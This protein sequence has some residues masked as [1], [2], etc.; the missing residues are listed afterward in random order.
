MKYFKDLFRIFV[1]IFPFLCTE[2]F[3]FSLSAQEESEIPAEIQSTARQVL[4]VMKEAASKSSPWDSFQAKLQKIREVGSSMFFPLLWNQRQAYVCWEA[5]HGLYML[6]WEKDGFKSGTAGE[7]F[8]NPGLYT[9]VAFDRLLLSDPKLLEEAV[10]SLEFLKLWIPDLPSSVK[11][12]PSLQT[13]QSYLFQISKP[14]KNYTLAAVIGEDR[15]FPDLT[16]ADHELC[17]LHFPLIHFTTSENRKLSFCK[18]EDPVLLKRIPLLL[19]RYWADTE[20]K[21]FFNKTFAMKERGLRDA[22]FND[23]LFYDELK[24]ILQEVSQKYDFSNIPEQYLKPLRRNIENFLVCNGIYSLEALKTEDAF[25]KLK[26]AER[27]CSAKTTA[28]FRDWREMKYLSRWWSER[29]EKAEEE[30]RPVKIK[31]YG[32]ST[33]QEI[34]SYAMD[35][36]S[37]GINNFKILASDIDPKMITEASE[38]TYS[39]DK[40]S[41]LTFKQYDQVMSEFFEKKE[42]G[43]YRLKYKKFFEDRIHFIVQD[44]TQPLPQNLPAEYA[45]PYDCISVKNVFLYLDQE[46]V[47]KACG[48]I[49]EALA[50]GGV[51]VIWDKEYRASRLT[52]ELGFLDLIPLSET[53]AFKPLPGTGENELI[54]CYEIFSD[55]PPPSAS[56]QFLK[57]AQKNSLFEAVRYFKKQSFKRNLPTVSSLEVQFDEAL[58]TEDRQSAEEIL[59]VLLRVEPR[60]YYPFYLRYCSRFPSGIYAL[61]KDFQVLKN[62]YAAVISPDYSGRTEEMMEKELLSLHFEGDV[63]PVI[64]LASLLSSRDMG[65]IPKVSP[66]E[67]VKWLRLSLR[68]L[69][70]AWKNHLRDPLIADMV[71][72]IAHNYYTLSGKLVLREFFPDLFRQVV[73]FLVSTDINS[74]SSIGRIGAGRM[75]LF[76]VQNVKQVREKEKYL[77]LVIKLCSLDEDQRDLLWDFQYSESF[78][79]SGLAYTERVKL[80]DNSLT[81]GQKREYLTKA[82]DCFDQ[83]LSVKTVYAPSDLNLRNQTKSYLESLEMEWAHSSEKQ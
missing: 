14:I 49:H 74:L 73:E 59:E 81:C 63:Q 26:I 47:K 69:E 9:P 67:D 40:F 43:L 2:E 83:V 70:N 46:S 4:T 79:V 33:G 66:S 20:M 52:S 51:T 41:T 13:L 65:R 28:F 53:I 34:L 23:D 27:F 8:P 62:L 78:A 22:V 80:K 54:S 31:V 57:Y 21:S 5:P 30:N 25:F 60:R 72:Q 45:P 50:P 44:V 36:F 6:A 24:T 75:I 68:L 77:E 82:I 48:I 16:E 64:V 17:F 29:S 3:C 19:N 76:Y 61:K 11:E 10:S 39:E 18:V 58:E 12:N 35:L 38:M 32:C 42:D 37:R 56:V 15:F 1:L 55:P 71:F 7:N